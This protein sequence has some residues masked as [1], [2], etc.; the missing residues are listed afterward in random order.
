MSHTSKSISINLP[1]CYR[2][3]LFLDD[4]N[5]DYRFN[6]PNLTMPTITIHFQ[7]GLCIIPGGRAGP[8]FPAVA[9]TVAF[10]NREPHSLRGIST[11]TLRALENLK[12]SPQTTQPPPRAVLGLGGR[13]PAPAHRQAR[14][15]AASRAPGRSGRAGRPSAS[16]AAS[17]RPRSRWQGRAAWRL[18]CRGGTTGPRPE[19]RTRAR[20]VDLRSRRRRASQLA[21][22]DG[23]T[24]ARR[25]RTPRAVLARSSPHSRR[26]PV[27]AAAASLPAGSR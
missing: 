12:H 9:L 1:K 23:W 8:G 22:G 5:Q 16:P 21:R 27:T 6:L 7:L 20:R 11:N 3:H 15:P 24:R 25:A 2:W 17:T 18:P 26:S 4:K 19:S 13:L 14:W 10:H